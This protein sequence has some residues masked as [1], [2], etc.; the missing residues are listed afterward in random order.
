V[1]L[2]HR[3]R[4]QPQPIMP[5]FVMDN[6]VSSRF[7]A[8]GARVFGTPGNDGYGTARLTGGTGVTD[9]AAAPG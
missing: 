8:T 2:A 4:T 5:R 3:L 1:G 7:A 9:G 6:G